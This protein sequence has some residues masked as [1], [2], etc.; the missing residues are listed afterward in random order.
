MFESKLNQSSDVALRLCCENRPINLFISKFTDW[1]QS[2]EKH[3]LAFFSR[4]DEKKAQ[5]MIF[6][7]VF[8]IGLVSVLMPREPDLGYGR[9]GPSADLTSDLLSWVQPAAKPDPTAA[10]TN[11]PATAMRSVTLRSLAQVKA[12]IAAARH[13]KL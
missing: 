13:S 2:L 5:G 10:A 8:W 7:A 1:F 3:W 9:P 11:A 6:R 12:E 4:A